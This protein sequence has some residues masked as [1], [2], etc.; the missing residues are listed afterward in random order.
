MIQ[1]IKQNKKAVLAFLLALVMLIGFIPFT[2]TEVQAVTI[3][4]GDITTNDSFGNGDTWQD[5]D[6]IKIERTVGY[7]SDCYTYTASVDENGITTWALDKK[8]YWDGKEEHILAAFYP[9]AGQDDY[10]S[11]ELPEDQSTLEK[12]KLADCMNAVWVGNPT[13]DPINFQMKHRL[14]MVT[15]NYEFASEFTNATVDNVKV[16]PSD[17]FVMFDAEDGG[18]MDEPYGV[19]GTTIDAYHDADNKTIQ[20]IVIPCTYPEG[21]L[22]MTLEVNGEELQVKMPEAKTLEEGTH[23]TFD[24]K[25]GKDKVTIEQVSVNGNDPSVPFGDGWRSDTEEDLGAVSITDTQDEGKTAWYDGDQIIAT[26]TS[27]YYGKQTAMLT[28]SGSDG[29][30]STDESFSYLENETPTVKAVYAPSN[31]LGTGEYIEFDCELNG[32]ELTVKLESATRNYSRLRI[33]GLPNKTLTVTTTEFTPAG[34]TSAATAPY[35]LTTDN[36]GNAFLYGTFAEGATISVKQGDVVLKEYAFT[37]NKHPGGTEQGKSY[38]LGAMPV[39][40]LSQYSDGDTI[41][42]TQDSVIVGDGNEYNISVNIA[43]DTIVTFDVGASGVKLGGQI[44][45]ADGKTLTLLVA[46]DAEHTVNGGISLGNG[47]NVIIE[48]DLTKANNKLTVTATDGNAGIGANG[49][50][51]AGDITIRNARVDA[52]GSSREAPSTPA[53]ISGAAIGTSDG[54]MGDILIENSVIVAEGGYYESTSH[55]P[56]I[57]IGYVGSTMGDIILKNSQ[58]TARNNGD[59]LASVIGAGANMHVDVTGTLGD[60]VITNTELNLSMEI[61]TTHYYAALIGSG[62]GKSYAYVNM[63]KIIFT[64]MKQEELDEVIPTWLPSDFNQYGAYALGKGYEGIVYK[65][66]TFGGVWVS[67]GNGGT[68]QIGD[69]SGYYNPE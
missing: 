48:G 55:A 43:E 32:A 16:I 9:A 13:T 39:I 37:A 29:T 58:I 41:N 38:V 19:F 63:G 14:S 54:S 62:V 30:W 24:L 4:V 8:L 28:F 47:S 51:T 25:V 1:T 12:L 53:S 21:Q 10:R 31:I 68:V 36:N 66:G 34:A 42:I 2:A 33:V 61:G 35:T 26:L 67:D 60:I 45:V 46:G 57:G 49:G 22:F 17:P 15:V 7:D 50:V 52:T 27:Q 6:Q 64:D 18:K 56:A 69:E 11:F 65:C 59:A 44:T 40:D 20:A 5:G 23:Y 3:P